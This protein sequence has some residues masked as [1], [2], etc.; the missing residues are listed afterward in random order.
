MD[1]LS[2]CSSCLWLYCPEHAG[3][4]GNERP[5]R[6]ASTADIISGLQLGRAEV[7][8][9]LKILLNMDRPEHH[10]VDRLKERGWRKEAADVP[11]SKVVNNLCSTRQILVLFWGQPWKSAERQGRA[12]MGLFECFYAILSWNWNWIFLFSCVMFSSH[13][14]FW[15]CHSVSMYEKQ[16]PIGCLFWTNQSALKYVLWHTWPSQSLFHVRSRSWAVWTIKHVQQAENAA[17]LDNEVISHAIP[18][19]G[20]P[21][22]S[23]MFDSQSKMHRESSAAWMTLIR[24][25]SFIGLMV[26]P[27]K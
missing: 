25:L 7:L 3:V 11:P 27:I 23:K 13:F 1:C 16:I 14:V 5:D 24:L 8:R 18:G 9:G 21:A 20:W 22:C 6:L 26:Q 10:S 4:S 15:R 12:C 2:I 17:C 19:R